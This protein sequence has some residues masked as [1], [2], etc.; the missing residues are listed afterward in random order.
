MIDETVEEI[1]EMQTHSSSVVAV[2]AAEAV[3][4]LTER[5]YP[6]VEEYLKGLERN[7]SALR[8]ANPSHASLHTTQRE[9]VERVAGSDPADVAEAKAETEAAVENVI[10]A[11]ES[12]KERAASRAAEFLD[13]RETILTHDYSSTVAGTV[14]E[15]LADGKTFELYVTESRPRFLGRKNARQLA[16]RA[17]VDVTLLVDSA[18]GHYLSEVDRVLVGM[19]CI[20]DGTLYNRI[21][22]YPIAAT[23]A[24]EGVPVTV[25]GAESKLVDGAFAFENELRSPSEVLREPAEG[26]E[27]VNPSYDATPTGLL[28]AV[29]TDEAIHRY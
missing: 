4:S 18:A 29:V 23:A 1:E 3:R 10:T 11:V 19:D 14:D 2:K 13:D 25:V 20:V 21:G 22:T 26:F 5:D 24:Q 28:D 17:G 8:R 15:A 12:A 7:S 9:I 27:V 6:T 16:Q